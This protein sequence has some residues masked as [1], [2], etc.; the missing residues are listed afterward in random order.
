LIFSWIK[1]RNV[2]EQHHQP[3]QANRAPGVERLAAA[4]GRQQDAN[5]E[6][7][8]DVDDQVSDE[9]PQQ[10]RAPRHSKSNGANIRPDTLAYYKGS[11]WKTVLER[12]KVKY[13]RFISLYHAFPTRDDHLDEAERILTDTIVECR[14]EG[15]ILEDGMCNSSS[16]D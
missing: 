15:F 1:D 14:D 11:P 10:Q 2:L 12:A 8:I 9:E 7:E 3:N 16:L 13:R 4:A 5:P 6:H